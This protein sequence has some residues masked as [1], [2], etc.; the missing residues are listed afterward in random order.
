MP[1][2]LFDDLIFGPVKSRRLGVSL[3]INLLPTHSKLC[4]FNCVY[5]ECGWTKNR[6]SLKIKLPNRD[7][8]KLLLVEKLKALKGTPLEPDSITFAGNGEPTLHPHFA[9]IINDTIELRNAFAPKAKIS[10]LSNGSMLNKQ[11]VFEALHKVDNNILKLD[12]GTEEVIRNINMPL[13]AFR[14]SEYI[15]QLKRFDGNLIIQSLFLRGTNNNKIIDNTTDFE[16]GAWLEKLQLIRP[17]SVMVYAI[18][19][20]T[21]AANLVKIS[22]EELEAIAQKV[23]AMG[24]DASVF[25]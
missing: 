14:L 20:D 15:D 25:A 3:G 12:G 9:E 17:K 19:R 10:V 6:S 21:P 23:T 11:S 22:E 4:S 7:D 13:K 1:V 24:I 18:E 2:F 16:I 5:C 8:F